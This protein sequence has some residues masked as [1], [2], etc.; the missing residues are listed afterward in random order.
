[1]PLSNPIFAICAAGRGRR[2]PRLSRGFTFTE[3]LF[4]VIILGIG[5]I[6]LAAM[7]PVALSQTKETVGETAGIQASTGAAAS[8]TSV[9]DGSDYYLGNVASPVG[10]ASF[11]E[12][13]GYSVLPSLADIGFGTT[14]SPTFIPGQAIA[15]GTVANGTIV[16]TGTF[17][18]PTNASPNAIN[19]NQIVP[20]DPR[21]AW[22]ILFRRDLVATYAY[23][24][25]GTTQF[26]VSPYAQL[27]CIP[28][29]T[30]VTSQFSPPQ[31]SNVGDIP[32][33]SFTTASPGYPNASVRPQIVAGS[34]N[35]DATT[36]TYYFE[37]A[38]NSTSQSIGPGSYLV[39]SDDDNLQSSSSNGYP[40]PFRGL[41]NGNV[42]RLGTQIPVAQDPDST[43]NLEFYF[44]PGW[45][46]QPQTVFSPVPGAGSMT[47]GYPPNAVSP[48]PNYYPIVGT[49]CAVGRYSQNGVYQ[50]NSQEI[51]A[52]VTTVKVQ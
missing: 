47:I 43:G 21:Y 5:F 12:N 26:N 45:E 36:S 11:N 9:F 51:G 46:F 6:M 2:H 4:A 48:A 16:P 35:F 50:G 34:I 14:N 42:Y 28:V 22:S 24:G 32:Q 38:G 29:A 40:S 25:G 10:G 13:L 20:S 7:F 44:A 52:F 30:G 8:I 15:L 31:A 37:T 33:G 39:V 49:F 1:M 27:I 3:V 18:T 41:L 23:T 19:L 17:V